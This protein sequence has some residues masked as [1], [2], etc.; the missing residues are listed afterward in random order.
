MNRLYWRLSNKQWHDFFVFFCAFFKVWIFFEF[1]DR[2]Q[3]THF[4]LEYFLQN[5]CYYPHTLRDSAV[6]RMQDFCVQSSEKV[7]CFKLK[8]NWSNFHVV[9]FHYALSLDVR[10]RFILALQLYKLGNYLTPVYFAAKDIKHKILGS[11]WT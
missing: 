6:S 2:G 8:S 9:V 11:I 5:Q 4:L 3:V 1:G 10:Q 7:R